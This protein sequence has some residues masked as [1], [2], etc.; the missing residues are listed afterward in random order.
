MYKKLA[1]FLSSDKRPEGTMTLPEVYGFFFAVATSPE[2]MESPEW[3][4]VVFNGE[5]PRYKSEKKQEKIE[6][7]L[8][9]VYQEVSE[10]VKAGEFRLPAWCEALDPP[11][12]NFSDEA[13]L[14]Y[15]ADGLFDGYDWLSDVWTSSMD[16][17][18]AETV[19]SQLSVLFCFSHRDE[20]QAFCR[21]AQAGHFSQEH[22][23]KNAIEK[24]PDAMAT[25][26][27]IGRTLAEG[28]NNVTPFVREV[29]VGRNDPCPCGS[30]NKYKK[31]CING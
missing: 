15:W 29:K 17:E 1:K 21:S 27:R 3:M 11:V 28:F 30:G 19:K 31:C 13:P 10:Q 16:E 26:G 12:E 9:E 23:A 4:P 22:R 5:E 2:P 25:F 24:F 7:A 20:A 8:H 14:A 18:L 6:S